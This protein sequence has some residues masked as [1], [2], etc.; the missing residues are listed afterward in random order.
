MLLVQSK[1]IAHSD[2]GD[3]G[4]TSQVRQHLTDECVEL[5]FVNLGRVNYI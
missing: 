4:C 3:A 5:A 1:R 2:H